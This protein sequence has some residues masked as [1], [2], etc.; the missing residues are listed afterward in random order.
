MA[1]KPPTPPTAAD[2]R[3]SRLLAAVLPYAP[4]TNLTDSQRNAIINRFGRKG[5][6]GLTEKDRGLINRANRARMKQLRE[7]G[8]SYDTATNK[9]I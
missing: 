5:A 1:K 3:M 7:L 2:V 4:L 6:K 8:V 9:P